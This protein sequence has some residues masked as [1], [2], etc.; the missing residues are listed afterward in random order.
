MRADDALYLHEILWRGAAHMSRLPAAGDPRPAYA[1]LGAM[2]L[3]HS[4]LEAYLNFVG[5][6]AAP[7]I[8]A[9]E[10][11]HFTATPYRGV[12]GKLNWLC[13][14]LAVAQD[15]SK[16]P[17]Q[18]LKA[19]DTWRN[20]LAHGKDEP[21]GGRGAVPNGL[22]DPCTAARLDVCRTAVRDVCGRLHEAAAVKHR[23]A[24]A[25]ARAPFGGPDDDA[26]GNRSRPRE[27]TRKESPAN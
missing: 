7:G 23:L 19:L 16:P 25:D 22:L 13:E 12:L 20:R 8:W 15:W 27:A 4:A 21:A 9:D 24:G 10:K 17:W 5:A 14:E 11:A 6:R 3:T 26:P 2:M 1:L 18:S